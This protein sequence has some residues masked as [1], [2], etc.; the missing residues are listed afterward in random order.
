MTED[1]DKISFAY[2][3]MRRAMSPFAKLLWPLFSYLLAYIFFFFCLLTY[4]LNETT[5]E[6][7]RER[8]RLAVFASVAG[9]AVATDTATD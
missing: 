9:E 2:D 1:I 8:E 4:F 6:R 5:R 3:V 7:E